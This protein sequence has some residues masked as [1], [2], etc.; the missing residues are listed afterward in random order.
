MT[1][2]TN[3]NL[4]WHPGKIVTLVLSLWGARGGNLRLRDKTW[5]DLPLSVLAPRPFV[6]KAPFC[7]SEEYFCWA[8]FD[9]LFYSCNTILRAFPTGSTY[10]DAGNTKPHHTWER[11]YLLEFAIR[12][13]TRMD[14]L[15]C[16]PGWGGTAHISTGSQTWGNALCLE[17]NTHHWKRGEGGS[18]GLAYPTHSSSPYAW[19]RCLPQPIYMV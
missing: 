10:Y 4:R 7:R 15:L 3:K 9:R 8:I 6:C 17:S 11:H 1:P 16:N 12:H 2:L 18:P 13:C 5:S 14:E 19:Q